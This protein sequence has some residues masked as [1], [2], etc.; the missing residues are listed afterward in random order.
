MNRSPRRPARVEPGLRGRV[1]AVPPFGQTR[2][3]WMPVIRQRPPAAGPYTR[4]QMPASKPHSAYDDLPPSFIQLYQQWT[5]LF[6]IL[7]RPWKWL[8][9]LAV[10]LILAVAIGSFL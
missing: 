4:R 3:A 8:V 5:L 6:K 7:D 9:A 10:L 1:A 2:T